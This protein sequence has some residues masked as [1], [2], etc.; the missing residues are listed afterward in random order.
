MDNVITDSTSRAKGWS[1]RDREGTQ[2]FT[3]DS[4]VVLPV[5]R[6]GETVA[7]LFLFH[8]NSQGNISVWERIEPVAS[9]RQAEKIMSRMVNIGMFLREDEDGPIFEYNR[10][11]LPSPKN[12][13]DD[14]AEERRFEVQELRARFAEYRKEVKAK[15]ES[16]I[17]Y[18]QLKGA[19]V[20]EEVMSV[21]E[22]KRQRD[23]AYGGN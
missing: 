16:N 2:K 12:V 7:A 13:G 1:I 6:N 20:D 4:F 3:R 22:I 17:D 9:I 8:K 23:F 15:G 14:Y 11:V 21:V 18:L 5:E 10:T 19:P